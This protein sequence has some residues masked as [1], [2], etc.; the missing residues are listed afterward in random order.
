MLAKAKTKKGDKVS[1]LWH[2][3]FTMCQAGTEPGGAILDDFLE[4]VSAIVVGRREARHGG[5]VKKNTLA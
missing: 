5:V 4:E 3:V 1:W 2:C